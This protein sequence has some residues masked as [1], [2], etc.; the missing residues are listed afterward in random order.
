MTKYFIFF[1]DS[2][3]FHHL[4]LLLLVLPLA[5]LEMHLACLEMQP[6]LLLPLLLV[7]LQR[8]PFPHL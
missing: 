7:Y 1:F 5:C 4:T 8:S 2:T 3:G 6:L